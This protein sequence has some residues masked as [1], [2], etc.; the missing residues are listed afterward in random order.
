ML[1][2]Q[3]LESARILLNSSTTQYPNGLANSS[4]VLGH[5]LMDHT[6][7][8]RRRQRR[9][10]RA[11]GAKLSM[12]APRRPT[13]LYTI[14]FRNTMN[15]PRDKDFI[16]GYGFQGGGSQTFNWAAPGF[17]D[18][19]KQA[20]MNPITSVGLV[21]FGEML[22]RFE[23]FVELDPAGTVDAYGIPVLKITMAWGENEQ[24]MIP[25]M[26]VSASEMMEAAGAKNIR[27]FTVPDR[28]PG[29]GIH[30]LGVARMG[31]DPKTSVLNQFCQAHDVKNLF[32]MDGA[33][34][35]RRAR[36]Q[37]PTL[38]IMALAVRSTRLPDGG[39]EEGESVISRAEA[40]PDTRAIPCSA[41]A[42]VRREAVVRC[43]RAIPCS[44]RLQAGLSFP[45]VSRC[46]RPPSGEPLIRSA[47]L[48]PTTPAA[49]PSLRSAR[50]GS[51]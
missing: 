33:G 13:G 3:A 7:G 4:G 28:I 20:V 51:L 16:R 29:Y 39:D 40:L 1:C 26:A 48:R 21:G 10:P 34:V 32:V 24:K 27:P 14:R 36:C 35:R 11:P 37:N 45:R 44:A 41:P 25:D 19:Y 6:V 31:A 38:T 23:N 2:A 47:V 15:G 12:A 49:A 42:A 50:R 17:G 22:P 18:A 30:E 9:V 46:G 5:Y 43:S 8:G